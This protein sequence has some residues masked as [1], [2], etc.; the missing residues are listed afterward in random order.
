MD[1]TSLVFLVANPPHINDLGD[2]K[3][4]LNRK[5]R[6]DDT[7]RINRKV[8]KG[9]HKIYE[10]MYENPFIYQGEISKHTGM[11]KNRISRYILE[12]YDR[13]ILLGPMVFLKPAE[14]YFLHAAF[15]EFQDPCTVYTNL[16]GFPCVVSRSWNC[17]KWNIMIVSDMKMDLTLLKGFY[18]CIYQGSKGVTYLS[19]VKYLDWGMS[20]KRIQD[21][22]TLPREKTTLYK[23]GPPIPWDTADWVFYEELKQNIRTPITP[24]L[25][26]PR[27]NYRSHLKWIKT[28][29]HYALV[30]PAFYPQGLHNYFPYV[31]L[32]S[33]DHH[34]QLMTILGMLPSTGVFFSVGN[35]LFARLTVLNPGEARE[36]F[37]LTT[38]LRKLNYFTEF[39]GATIIATPETHNKRDPKREEAT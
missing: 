32:F 29:P 26:D 31:F 8:L 28:V 18:R 1:F 30:Q 2:D 36:L 6:V 12:M 24:L 21:V 15:C 27:I 16:E 9:F 13:S 17:G 3:T 14:N 20:M 25:K 34:Q 7:V 38:K 19:R 37:S 23:M 35:Y 39:E 11:G 33:S 4:Q 22:L 5:N 10:Q